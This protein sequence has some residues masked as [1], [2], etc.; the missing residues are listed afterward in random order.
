[1]RPHAEHSWDDTI[2]AAIETLARVPSNPQLTIEPTAKGA[3]AALEQLKKIGTRFKP[4]STLGEGGMGIVHLAEQLTLGRDVAI[5]TL[6][7]EHCT[8][9]AVL[10]LVQEAWVTGTLEHPNVVPVYDIDFPGDAEGEGNQPRIILKKIEGTVWGELMRDAERVKREYRAPDLLE[11]N[12]RR[13]IEVCQALRYAHSRGIVHRDIKPENVMI[14]AFGEVYVLD[15][16]IAVA[17]HDDGTGRFPLAS[18]AKEMAGTPCCMSPEQLGGE[19]PNITPRTDIYLVGAM[20]YEMVTGLPPHTGE[21]FREILASVLQSNPYLPDDVPEDLARIIRRAM[22]PDPDARFETA[23][24]L[25]LALEGFLAHRG[26]SQLAAQGDE[27]AQR[28]VMAIDGG[29][30]SRVEALYTECAFAYR[31]ALRAWEQNEH[32]RIQF[33]RVTI[34]RIDHELEKGEVGVASR[35]L[36]TMEEPP[37][38]LVRRVK[39]AQAAAEAE[40]E[41]HRR[42]EQD[43]SHDVGKRTRAFVGTI[44]ATLWAGV[45]F[46]GVIQ[47]FTWVEIVLG[48]GVLIVLMLGFGYWARESFSKTR[49]N[50]SMGA[51]ALGVLG[52]QL[53][54]LYGAYVAGFELV[55]AEILMLFLWA[56]GAVL[57]V[58]TTAWQLWPAMVGYAAGFVIAAWRPDLRYW[59]M[60][61]GHMLLLINLGWFNRAI[62]MFRE[63]R[64]ERRGRR[65][66]DV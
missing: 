37:K 59:M 27:I 8:P 56:A 31:A 1:M 10:K 18:E 36:A 60:A 43:A 7:P 34:L 47:P 66:L 61:G 58:A 51:V 63:A 45:S 49:L 57:T 3:S 26:S 6:K 28:M 64:H 11:W 32:A 17:L 20:L 53:L 4:R 23:E 40:G 29:E 44:M 54:L 25:Q 16:G 9:Q 52:V 41:L 30:A 19:E 46:K 55:Q 39:K 15:W 21:S 14:G 65:R 62:A 5:K 42:M 48:T 2:D 22:D 12:I 13:V 50:R 38:A 35:L 33:Q 24:Q